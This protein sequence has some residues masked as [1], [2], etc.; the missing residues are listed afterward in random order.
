VTV[1]NTILTSHIKENSAGGISV[2]NYKKQSCQLNLAS[3]GIGIIS[4]Y[5][6]P[7]PRRG[8]GLPL[9]WNLFIIKL[10]PLRG[11]GGL[12]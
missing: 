10:C 4:H 6:P 8:Q 1:L 3:K 7:H 12:S 2:K 11:C 9:Q 5:Q